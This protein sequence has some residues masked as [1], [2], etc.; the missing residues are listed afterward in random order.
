MTDTA[1]PPGQ[2]QTLQPPVPAWGGVGVYELEVPEAS[3]AA[4]TYVVPE[5]RV[6]RLVVARFAYET[7][8]ENQEHTL[9]VSYRS[10]NGNSFMPA[11]VICKSV[12]SAQF[13]LL[14]MSTTAPVAAFSVANTTTLTLP[15]MLL[16]PNY[17]VVVN[18]QSPKPAD[19]WVSARLYLESFDRTIHTDKEVMQGVRLQQPYS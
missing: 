11:R 15:S 13:I 3:H 6:Q 16:L 17:E 10:E 18:A 19:R 8:S 14:I 7:E 9:E 12:N 2:F 1:L 4:L 5:P